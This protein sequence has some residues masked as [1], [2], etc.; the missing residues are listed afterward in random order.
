ML[1]K[2]A[3]RMLPDIMGS[4][5]YEATMA[6]LLCEENDWLSSDAEPIRDIFAREVGLLEFK[7]RNSG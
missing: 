2:I 7:P 4:Q 1:I 3:R 5:Y 6:C